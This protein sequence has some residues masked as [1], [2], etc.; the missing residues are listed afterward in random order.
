MIPELTVIVPT[1]NERGNV[2]ELVRRLESVLEGV[3]WEVLFVDDD[4]T[5]GT[6]EALHG[7]ARAKEHVRYLRRVGR[8]GLSSACIEG[9]GASSS[10]Y[11]AVMDADLQ[12]DESLLP[13][14]LRILKAGGSELVV[15]S[16]YVEGGGVGDWGRGRQ[17]ASRLATR[18]GRLAL[19]TPLSDPMSGFFMLPR[20]LYEETVHRVSGKGFKILLDI[21]ASAGRPLVVAEL[22]FVF[23]LRQAGESK[24]NT[25][26]MWEYLI[27]LAD[28]ILGPRIPV[29]FVLFVLVG[30]LGALLHLLI[31]RLSLEPLGF[32]V[33]QT[34]GTLVAMVGNFALNNLFTYRD[35]RL[36]G[37]AMVHGLIAF[38]AVC[39][40]GAI[41]NIRLALLVFEAGLPWWLAGLIGAAI[42]SVWN[43]A[44]SATLVW[45]PE[46][47]RRRLPAS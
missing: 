44:V 26:V 1:L 4:S 38:L 37:G 22:P 28:K 35:L 12:H 41:V 24:L 17:W 2:E 9:M 43:Y 5:D 15:C 40:I 29:R 31:L 10:P 32:L 33:G 14:M 23:R 20:E 42:G 8:R 19:P 16:R 27:L 6:V 39:S 46:T 7:L 47:R 30:A 3:R 45:T 18:L 25:L 34:V 36:K 21:V 11:M 13:E